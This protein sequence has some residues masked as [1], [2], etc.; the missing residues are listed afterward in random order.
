MKTPAWQPGV[1]RIAALA[2][3]PT[4]L[5]SFWHGATDVIAKFVPHYMTPCWYTPDPASL[6][7]TSHVQEGLPEFPAE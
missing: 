4:E 3:Q 5:V 7:I 6:Q 1:D 2:R